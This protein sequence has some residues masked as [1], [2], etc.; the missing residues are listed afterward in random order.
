MQPLV[1][2]SGSNSCSRQIASGTA[3]RVNILGVGVSAVSMQGA[4]EGVDRFFREMAPAMSASP[5]CTAS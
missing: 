3:S 1:E 4:V 2:V 5:A